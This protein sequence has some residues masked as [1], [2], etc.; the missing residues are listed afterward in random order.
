MTQPQYRIERPHRLHGSLL[1][2]DRLEEL[3]SDRSLAVAVA[4]KSVQDPTR[5]RVRVVHIATGEVVFETASRHC[6]G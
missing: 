2:V 5:E 3:Y 1:P 4:V 6:A